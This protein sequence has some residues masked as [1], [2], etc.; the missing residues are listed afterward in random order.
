MERTVK[1]LMV[2]AGAFIIASGIM[3]G[4]HAVS[5]KNID[6]AGSAGGMLYGAIGFL[7][8]FGALIFAAA[9]DRKEREKENR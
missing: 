9:G 7:F 3:I 1:V 5:G 8:G 2:L 4:G 6:T